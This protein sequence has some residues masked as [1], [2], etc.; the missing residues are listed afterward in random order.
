MEK[1]K[2]ISVIL[3]NLLFKFFDENKAISS[4][5]SQSSDKIYDLKMYIMCLINHEFELNT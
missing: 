3:N 4:W 1:K 5:L 2:T